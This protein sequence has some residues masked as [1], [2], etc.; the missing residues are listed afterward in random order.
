[1][2]RTEERIYNYGNTL[3]V[4]VY[5]VVDEGEGDI[6]DIPEGEKTAPIGIKRIEK[7]TNTSGDPVWEAL[8]KNTNIHRMMQNMKDF[9]LEKSELERRAQQA[10]RQLALYEERLL[11]STPVPA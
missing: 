11:D 6:V 2:A 8:P 1:M 4:I 5:Q 9:E 7:N 10:E 3:R